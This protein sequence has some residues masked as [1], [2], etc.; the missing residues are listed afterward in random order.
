[1][2]KLVFLNLVKMVEDIGNPI[3]SGKYQT[4]TR[5]QHDIFVYIN[6][7]KLGKVTKRLFGVSY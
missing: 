4:R 5:R 6:S 2:I 1:M 7:S 3:S